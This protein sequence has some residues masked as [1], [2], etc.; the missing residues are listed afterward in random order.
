MSEHN[1]QTKVI[2]FLKSEG[3]YVVNNLGSACQRRGISDLTACVKGRFIAIELKLYYNKPSPLQIYN[4]EAVTKSGGIGILL[5]DYAFEEFKD[6]I[7]NFQPDFKT[8][9]YIVMM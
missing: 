9:K 7:R 6:F 5:Y 2:K 4:I 3:Y 1:F 8:D